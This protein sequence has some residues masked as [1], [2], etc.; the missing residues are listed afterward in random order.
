MPLSHI[1]LLL[2]AGTGAGVAGMWLLAELLAPRRPRAVD[3]AVPDPAELLRLRAAL[4]APE[5]LVCDS[6]TCAH[7]T[8]PHRRTVAEYATCTF[9]GT[10]AFVPAPT[11]PEG[12]DA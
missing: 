5:W 7:M 6:T 4:D 11:A 8:T 2:A 12:T 9:C 10:H 1:A 3:A